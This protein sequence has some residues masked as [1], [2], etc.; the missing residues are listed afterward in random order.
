M[1]RPR[2]PPS[3]AR[4]VRGFTLLEIVLA[5][6]LF[7]LLMGSYYT[8]FI[9]VVELEEHARS[10]RALGSAGPVVLD[11]IEDDLLSLYTH[12]RAL[13]A[14]PFRGDDDA[15]SSEAA[16]RLNFTVQ[17]ASIRQEKWHSQDQWVRC[18]VNEVGY[19]LG[20]HPS[21]AEDLRRLFRRESFYVDSAPTSGGDYYEI[22]DRVVA[23]D[24]QYV[25]FRVEE[26]ER[27]D[28]ETLGQHQYEIFESWAS[29]ERKAYPTAVVVTLT[30]EPPRLSDA[31]AQAGRAPVRRTFVRVIP[32]VQ[33]K[34]ITRPPTADPAGQAPPANP[35]S[36]G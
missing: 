32:L 27:T 24:L 31:P 1:S 23:L 22:Y 6:S 19:R 28:Q 25:G 10:Q 35:P 16:D 30:I 2:T 4:S 21:G 36:G 9:H 15:L 33:G 8:I 12:P 29:D 11:L 13:D 14:F 18:P 20:R 7:A 17:R 34:D 5:T 26:S 3:R